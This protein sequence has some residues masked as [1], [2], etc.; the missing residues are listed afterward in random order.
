MGVCSFVSFAV[1]A[2]SSGAVEVS[3]SLLSASPSS[4][5]PA[6][7][8]PVLSSSCSPSAS[9]VCPRVF[10]WNAQGLCHFDLVRARRKMRC[11]ASLLA[12]SDVMCILESHHGR[13]SPD[14]FLLEGWLMAASVPEFSPDAAGG[15]GG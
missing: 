15:G 1:S 7:P 11:F 12:F 10:L 5:D 8:G 14:L 9:F 13:L 6:S 4:L 3:S 2:A